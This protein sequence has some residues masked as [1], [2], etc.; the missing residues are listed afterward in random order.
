MEPATAADPGEDAPGGV[1]VIRCKNGHGDPVS[2]MTR[3]RLRYHFLCPH[4]FEEVY[5]EASRVRDSGNRRLRFLPCAKCETVWYGPRLDEL[6]PGRPRPGPSQQ[7][8]QDHEW[9]V[10]RGNTV[11]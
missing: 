11:P 10:R 5:P 9:E 3:L 4:D 1:I 6:L 7:R 8:D 2:A